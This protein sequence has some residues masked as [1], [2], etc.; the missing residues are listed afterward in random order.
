MEGLIFWYILVGISVFASS[1]SQLL[2]KKSANDKYDGFF[3]S[4]LNWRVIT[5]YTIFF[6][7]LLVNIS[8]MSRGV[9]LKDIPIFESLGYIFVPFLSAIFLNEKIEK[10]TLCSMLLIISGIV[11]FYL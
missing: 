1:C 3:K 2:L 4:M 6:G 9:N 10:R 11:V 5:A 8:A 7:A